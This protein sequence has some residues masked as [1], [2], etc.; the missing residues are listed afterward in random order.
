MVCGGGGASYVLPQ[1]SYSLRVLKLGSQSG[2]KSKGTPP[3]ETDTD[4]QDAGAEE[5]S[6]DIQDGGVDQWKGKNAS[7][8]DTSTDG[9]LVN[10]GGFDVYADGDPDQPGNDDGVN[11]SS[12]LAFDGNSD[13]DVPGAQPDSDDGFDVYDDAP[14]DPPASVVADDDDIYDDVVM[15][16]VSPPKPALDEPPAPAPTPGPP[17]TEV[18]D[19]VTTPAPSRTDALAGFD[20]E[21]DGFNDSD[22]GDGHDYVNSGG[23]EKKEEPRS[24]GAELPDEDEDATYVNSGA[25]EKN[26]GGKSSGAE[27][28]DEDEDATYV[29]SGAFEKNEG[30][31]SGGAELPDEDDDDTYGTMNHSGAMKEAVIPDLHIDPDLGHL[32]KRAS[33]ETYSADTAA[34]RE[35]TLQKQ[36]TISAAAADEGSDPYASMSHGQLTGGGSQGG[37]MYTNT[38]ELG[39]FDADTDADGSNGMYTNTASLAETKVADIGI[40]SDLSHLG[41]APSPGPGPGFDAADYTNMSSLNVVESPGSDDDHD[42]ADYENSEAFEKKDAPKGLRPDAGDSAPPISGKKPSPRV[43]RASKTPAAAEVAPLPPARNTVHVA[44]EPPSRTPRSRSPKPPRSRSPKPLRKASP[45]PPR[46]KSPKTKKKT[47]ITTTTAPMGFGGGPKLQLPGQ[48]Y[49]SSDAEFERKRKERLQQ[50]RANMFKAQGK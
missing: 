31:K 42:A 6:T 49:A 29:N 12:G 26:E 45:K 22:G 17:Q 1:K 9:V 41:P 20:F 28:P 40:D 4:F 16:T 47:A 38:T 27:L 7:E 24:G 18:V 39:G 8:T 10:T 13:A 5:I 36:A 46:Q 30:G 33:V 3:P 2:K 25:F 44:P 19:L 35:L 37:G 11:D 14:I 23:F 48:Q 32:S 50:R 34:E 21:D 43:N 15:A